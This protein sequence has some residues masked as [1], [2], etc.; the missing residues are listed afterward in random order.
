MR[1]RKGG[2]VCVECEKFEKSLCV[3]A[4]SM[5]TV[6]CVG[7]CNEHNKYVYPERRAC[8]SFTLKANSNGHKK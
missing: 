1:E 4:E 6:R 3:M 8:E 2:R 7:Y 5:T